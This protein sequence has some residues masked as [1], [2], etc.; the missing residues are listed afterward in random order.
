MP[1]PKIQSLFLF[2]F[3][4]FW[5]NVAQINFEN[6]KRKIQRIISD[7]CF[8]LKSWLNVDARA[9]S[10]PLLNFP[11]N[12][13]V[14]WRKMK[15]FTQ[16]IAISWNMWNKSIASFCNKPAITRGGSMN[17][18]L[19][20]GG[21]ALSFSADRKQTKNIT[22]QTKW[23]SPKK[24][25]HFPKKGPDKQK[26]VITSWQNKLTNTKNSALS[27]GVG[28]GTTIYKQ[29]KTYNRVTPTCICRGALA[30]FAPPPPPITQR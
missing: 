13:N 19:G 20:G 22:K 2:I 3:L 8:Q 30:P 10:I 11:F 25:P 24:S 16:I 18:L 9:P 15:S 12:C 27:V 23:S 26:K 7:S 21:G 17:F 14:A 1:T 5:I 28:V 29:E 4:L 6:I